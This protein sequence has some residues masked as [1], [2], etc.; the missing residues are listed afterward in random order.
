MSVLDNGYLVNAVSPKGLYLMM[1]LTAQ[2]Q[3]G[4][5]RE[6]EEEKTMLSI[7]HPGSINQQIRRMNS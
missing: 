3:L 7:I 1:L 2:A 4:G 6:V 5:L